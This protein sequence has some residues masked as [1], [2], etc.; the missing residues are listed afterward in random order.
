MTCTLLPSLLQWQKNV[1]RVCEHVVGPE[2]LLAKG[3]EVA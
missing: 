2:C 3:A 1:S